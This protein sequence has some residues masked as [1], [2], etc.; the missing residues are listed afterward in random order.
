MIDLDGD[1]DQDIITSGFYGNNFL[2]FENGSS[3]TDIN[4]V[5]ESIK[6]Y[7][8]PTTNNLN[9]GSNIKFDKI[10]VIDQLGKYYYFDNIDKSLNLN[11]LNKGIYI[12]NLYHKETVYSKKFTK[13]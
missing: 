1:G 9:I 4:E 3:S 13:L 11:K 10:E 7:P 2:Y 12:I 6:I 8:N 5:L